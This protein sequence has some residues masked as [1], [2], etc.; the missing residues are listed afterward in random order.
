MI[1]YF[2]AQEQGIISFS[3]VS[4]GKVPNKVHIYGKSYAWD[5]QE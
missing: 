4:I 2:T 1:G 3:I 5:C